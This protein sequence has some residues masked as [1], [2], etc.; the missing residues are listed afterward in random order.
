MPPMQRF[1]IAAG[2]LCLSA[3]SATS[4]A[5][6]LDLGLSND[7]AMAAYGTN[8]SKDIST[9]LTLL[10]A[11][12]D[13]QRST[14]ASFGFFTGQK[15]GDIQPR[16]GAKVFGLDGEGKHTDIYGIALALGADFQLAPKLSF[17]LDAAYAPHIITG[18]DY[19]HYYDVAARFSYQLVQ[20]G[21]LYVGYQDMQAINDDNEHD[22]EISQGAVFGVKFLF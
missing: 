19:D 8:Y 9:Q 2:L 14:F 3:F 4:M 1:T 21:A 7:M 20:N 17:S 18:G 22:Y 15:Y 11:N 12:V 6:S 5:D 16:L 10:H 13:E